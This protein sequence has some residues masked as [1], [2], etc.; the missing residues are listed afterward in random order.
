MEIVVGADLRFCRLGLCGVGDQVEIVGLDV[1]RKSVVTSVETFRKI[2]QVGEAG[3]NVGCPLRGVDRD[4]V[5][6]GQVLSQPGCVTPHRRFEA[7]VYVLT[8]GEEGGRH[9]PFFRNYRPQLYFRTTNMTGPVALG[10]GMEMVILI[11]GLRRRAPICWRWCVRRRA[12]RAVAPV[13]IK[14]AAQCGASDG[15]PH[16]NPRLERVCRVRHR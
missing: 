1:T 11:P 10:E 13:R 12:V 5:E 8:K 9:T 15:T 2:L 16:K 3:D 6:R 14:S 7:E 4:A